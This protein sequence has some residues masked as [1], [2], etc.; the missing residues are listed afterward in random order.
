MS[1][2]CVTHAAALAIEDLGMERT[3]KGTEAARPS[4]GEA[5]EPVV[6]D[7]RMTMWSLQHL[8]Y[9][10]SVG[11]QEIVDELHR[12][13]EDYGDYEDDGDFLSEA[14][15]SS[16]VSSVAVMDDSYDMCETRTS[17]VQSRRK[18]L[19]MEGTYESDAS[20]VEDCRKDAPDQLEEKSERWIAATSESRQ[21]P[22]LAPTQ[23]VGEERELD[24]AV[25]MAKSVYNYSDDEQEVAVAEEVE[26][27][28]AAPIRDALEML[29]CP[30]DAPTRL[31]RAQT[32]APRSEKATYQHQLLQQMQDLLHVVEST[33][34]VARANTEAALKERECDRVV[35]SVSPE[36]ASENSRG[37][38]TFSQPF[39]FNFVGL[40]SIRA[41]T[42]GIFK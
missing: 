29:A 39:S 30:N 21:Q 32:S 13:T 33:Y 6:L 38:R 2:T 27:V 28:A 8:D 4:R 36:S 7:H 35:H 40:R 25:P 41:R 10:L 31:N 15:R 3:R 34:Q 9:V 16:H 11:E 42:V 14:G 20:D 22:P 1:S 12:G 26:V 24:D 5:E 37:V 18:S 19:I 17:D 23:E